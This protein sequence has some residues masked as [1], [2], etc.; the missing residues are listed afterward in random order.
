ME[1][2]EQRNSKVEA[3]GAM[4][5]SFKDCPN[6]C[7]D[8]Y[9]FDPYRQGSKRVLCP[10]CAEKR[11]MLAKQDLELKGDKSTIV[12]ALN[13]PESYTGYGEFNI[14][15]VLPDFA[16]T[17]LKPESVTAVTEKLNELVE[18]ISVGV[19]PDYSIL[20]NLGG[21]A[22]SSNLVYTL[23]IRAYLSGLTVSPLLTSYDVCMA[24]VQD[25]RGTENKLAY[26]ELFKYDVCVVVLDA[27]STAADIGAVKGLM[28]NRAHKDKIT[29]IVAHCWYSAVYDLIGDENY[30]SKALAT[31][32]SVEYVEKAKPAQPVRTGNADTINRG[33]MSANQ[34]K[35]LMSPRN[36]L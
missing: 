14:D 30:P 31:L 23:L 13:L 34:L 7:R 1:I 16:K 12:Q 4:V 5:M 20:I 29:I 8:G 18:Q 10:Y 22:F 25:Y 3:V 33:S 9:Y 17:W 15:S 19:L 27:G 21:K 32:I 36:N 28:Q 26:A 24:R 35:D 6:G 11:K 2:F